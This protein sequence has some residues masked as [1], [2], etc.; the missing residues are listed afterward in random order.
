MHFML[1]ES[2]YI[3]L[4]RDCHDFYTSEVILYFLTIISQF[5]EPKGCFILKMDI[6]TFVLL[7]FIMVYVVMDPINHERQD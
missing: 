3:L 1:P 5:A 6:P 2:V 7:M 4:Q